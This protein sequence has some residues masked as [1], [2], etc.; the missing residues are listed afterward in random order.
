MP[1]FLAT[2]LYG[3]KPGSGFGI[4]TVNEA[5]TSPLLLAFLQ[6]ARE[7]RL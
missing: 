4:G 1:L 6:S 7:D 3:F 2:H 5:D